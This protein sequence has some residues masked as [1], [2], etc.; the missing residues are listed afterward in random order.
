[1]VSPP[2]ARPMTAPSGKAPLGTQ[3]RGHALAQRYHPCGALHRQHGVIAPERLALELV[4]VQRCRCLFE[5]VAS[6]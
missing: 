1:M 2:L 6:E 5:A 3:D 4:T